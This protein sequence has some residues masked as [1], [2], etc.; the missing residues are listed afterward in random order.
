MIKCGSKYDDYEQNY[1]TDRHEA[2]DVVDDR[3]NRYIPDMLKLQLRMPIWFPMKN[4]NGEVTSIHVDLLTDEKHIEYRSRMLEEAKLP[5][6]VY[7]N[8]SSQ[9]RIED[10]KCLYNHP[11]GMCRCH[12]PIYHI[13]QDEAIFKGGVFGKKIWKVNGVSPLRPKN[14]T[15]GWM[16]SAFQ[17]EIRGFGLSLSLDELQLVNNCRKQ[18]GKEELL[19]SPGLTFF[20]YGKNNDGYWNYD[21]FIK[22]VDDILDTIETLYP[23]MQVLL[24]VDHSGTHLKK[25]EGGLDVGVM[26]IGWGGKQTKLRPTINLNK[27]F[28]S[29]L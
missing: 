1:Y 23:Y 29:I 4:D 12:M 18:L 11:F 22:Q 15:P 19:E 5:G 14:E 24:E 8:N 3:N 20:E 28:Y 27:M 17:D 6:L 9:L 21:L 25:K 26:N 10:G 16:V 2:G 13:G 7:D